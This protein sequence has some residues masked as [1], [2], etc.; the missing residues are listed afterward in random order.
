M[1]IKKQTCFE[2]YRRTKRCLMKLLMYIHIKKVHFDIDPNPKPVHFIPHPVPWI[3]LKTFKREDSRVRWIS[4]SRQLN[5]V[6]IWHKQYPLLT[7][8]DILHKCSG[9]KFF[10]KL[11]N[12]MQYYMFELDNKSQDSCTIITSFG[13]YKYWRL[14]MGL[15]CSPDIAWVIMETF[16]RK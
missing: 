12:S 4:N 8:T 2:C 9:Y 3:H 15:K 16:F 14:L 6:L 11:Y 1:H 7:T 10:T 13:K 5:R